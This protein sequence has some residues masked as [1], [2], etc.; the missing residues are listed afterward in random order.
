VYLEKPWSNI[1]VPAMV[2]EGES[3]KIDFIPLL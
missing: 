1:Y 3:R 2:G